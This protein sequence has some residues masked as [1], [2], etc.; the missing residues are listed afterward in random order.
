MQYCFLHQIKEVKNI[1]ELKKCIRYYQY[2]T[3]I[4]KLM[5][6]HKWFYKN[7]IGQITYK[8]GYNKTPINDGDNFKNEKKSNFN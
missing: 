8:V 7:I 3:T 6:K 2:F 1:Y 5:K 4:N